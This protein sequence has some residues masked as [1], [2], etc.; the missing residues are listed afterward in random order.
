MAI[1]RIEVFLDGSTEPVRVLKEPPFKLTLNTANLPDGDHTLRMVTYYTGGKS[2]VKTIPFK[3]SNLPGLVVEGLEAG[4]EITGDLEVTL[5]VA[6][7]EQ[8]V[9]SGAF[10][11]VGSVIA[12]AVILLGIWLF[13][14]LTPTADHIV[15]EVSPPA[16]HGAAADHSTDTAAADTG[17]SAAVDQALLT[18]GGE[19]YNANCAGC[20]QAEGAGM[21]PM[22]PRLA[23]NP[24]L[25]DAA[26][27]T[28]VVINGLQNKEIVVDGQ[29]YNG[30][31]PG[32]GQLSD[33][34]VAAVATFIRN[35]W[36]NQH[37]GVTAE[38]AAA[39]R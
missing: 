34:D 22:F 35:S 28:N 20:H 1:Q 26:Y 25:A 33:E 8:P 39:Q 15:E 37:G 5:R 7:A 19:V 16:A 14:V 13:F 11:A 29:T 9:T 2:E 17:T 6:D 10:P 31:M 12:T 21:A 23:N 27:V 38:T 18:K 4:K 24:N 36:G 30:V 3:V 32:F